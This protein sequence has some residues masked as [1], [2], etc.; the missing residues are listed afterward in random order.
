M[1]EQ[2]WFAQRQVITPF[3]MPSGD[4]ESLDAP[5]ELFKETVNFGLLKEIP[6]ARLVLYFRSASGTMASGWR[7]NSYVAL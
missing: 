6:D 2:F 1:P 7:S 3:Y 4:R 5:N